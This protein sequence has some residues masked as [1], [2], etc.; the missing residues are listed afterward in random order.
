MRGI[1]QSR[2]VRL[3]SCP[4]VRDHLCSAR[5][6][7]SR[8]GHRVLAMRQAVKKTRRVEVAGPRRVDDPLHRLSR[9][10]DGTVRP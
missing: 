2:D 10:L 5:A 7:K 4:E 6:T 1:D 8:G 9:H 3:W